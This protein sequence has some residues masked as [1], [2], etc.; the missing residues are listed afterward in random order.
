VRKI[1]RRGFPGSQIPAADFQTLS[2]RLIDFMRYQIPLAVFVLLGTLAGCSGDSVESRVAAMNS[3]NI[4]RISN[5]YYAYQLRNGY[6]GPKDL[7]TL[8][9]FTQHALEPQRLEMMGI[10]PDEFDKLTISERDGKPFKIRYSVHVGPLDPA[11]AIVF[12]DTGVDGVRQVGFTNSTVQDTDDARYKEL[13]AGKPAAS[14]EGGQPA[15]NNA[16][17]KG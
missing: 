5:L 12:E 2:K 11:A 4:K 1:D 7:A 9:E 10:K 3:N 14:A 17:G 13:W 15:D 6:M 16:K 8:K